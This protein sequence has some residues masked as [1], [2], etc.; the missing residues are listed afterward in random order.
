[1]S[2]VELRMVIVSLAYVVSYFLAWHFGTIYTLF[3]F[4]SDV[5]GE[6]LAGLPLAAIFILTLALHTIGGKNVWQWNAASAFPIVL[7]SAI[8]FP[9]LFWII[10]MALFLVAWYLGTFLKKALWKLAPGVMA[11]IN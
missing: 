8:A 2:I 1:M 10:F 11:K 5:G 4:R 9:V 6:G 7:Y 3:L